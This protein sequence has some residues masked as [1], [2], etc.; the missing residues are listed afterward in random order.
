MI[1]RKRYQQSDS[2]DVNLLIVEEINIS[3]INDASQIS[4]F[5]KSVLKQHPDIMDRKKD[6]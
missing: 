4:N 1:T 2:E 3:K 5:K 6:T